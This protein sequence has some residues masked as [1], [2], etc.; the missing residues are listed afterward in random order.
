MIIRRIITLLFLMQM[1]IP[2]F[3]DESDM[4]KVP[5]FVS[6]KS[7]EVNMR[8]G[9]GADYPIKWVYKRKHLP[10]E[11]VEEYDNWR[12]I[13]DVDGEWGW[14]L[15]TMLDGRR[16]AIVKTNLEPAYKRPDVK[17]I[18]QMRLEKGA[19]V[20]INSCQQ[21]WCQVTGGDDI[22]GW[23]NRSKLFGIYNSENF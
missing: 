6:L 17:S 4:L 7:D 14:V 10:V 15:K 12:K 18:M 9:P 2:A 23:L 21:Q 3:A 1:P 16:Y 13:R 5:R 19:L 8:K 22:S 11:V 20:K